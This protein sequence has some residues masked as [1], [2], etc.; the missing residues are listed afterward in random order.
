MLVLAVQRS[1]RGVV[2][3][4]GA[5]RS[6]ADLGDRAVRERTVT[7]RLRGHVDP[8]ERGRL[9]GRAE[10]GQTIVAERR[11]VLLGAE[12]GV[13]GVE[14]RASRG[15]QCRCRALSRSGR[16][17][18]TRGR[19]GT[20]DLDEY[21][22]HEQHEDRGDRDGLTKRTNSHVSHHPPRYGAMRV[23]VKPCLRR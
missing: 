18:H 11:G 1:E 16:G 4:T 17:R 9:V 2:E 7:E 10:G 8:V 19:A 13:A 5:A 20:S 3:W 14:R 12:L 21:Q 15:R 6:G 23:G 22:R